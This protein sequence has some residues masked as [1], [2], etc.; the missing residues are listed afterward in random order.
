MLDVLFLVPTATSNILSISW[1]NDLQLNGAK[2]EVEQVGVLSLHQAPASMA[3]SF[4]QPGHHRVF[5][6][7]GDRRTGVP[8]AQRDMF[9]YGFVFTFRSNKAEP[10]NWNLLEKENCKC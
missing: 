2:Q 3:H 8:D 10:W 5:A 1:I 7:A 9:T 4:H 6:M